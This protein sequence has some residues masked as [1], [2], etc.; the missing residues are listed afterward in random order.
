MTMDDEDDFRAAMLDVEP[1]QKKPRA[2][3]RAQPPEQGDAS[4]EATPAQ[5]ERRQA[6]LGNKSKADPNPLT[7]EEVPCASIEEDGSTGTVCTITTCRTRKC[8]QGLIDNC[9]VS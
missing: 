1:L 9:A 7:L 8:G 5:L 6:A 3:P 4:R 2:Q